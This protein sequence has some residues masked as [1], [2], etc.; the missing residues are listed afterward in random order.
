[1]FGQI[2]LVLSVFL[3]V[4]K[5]VYQEFYSEDLTCSGKPTVKFIPKRACSTST[6]E[7]TCLNFINISGSITTCPD[8]VVLPPDWASLQGW[9][10]SESCS[11][12]ADYTIAIPPNKC[13]GYWD[14][15]TMQLDCVTS[16]IK[17]CEDDAANC[18][19]C[20]SKPANS[21]GVCTAG[22]PTLNFPMASYIFTCPHSCP[23]HHIANSFD[24][25]NPASTTSF[26]MLLITIVFIFC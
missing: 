19:Q 12:L 1:M 8:T 3:L 11:G 23:T 5:S 16:S 25:P 7:P 2:I 18:H 9:G 26:T 21:K 24:A 6:V 14:G 13:S 17:Q 4:G 20:P 15:P 10:S 22:N